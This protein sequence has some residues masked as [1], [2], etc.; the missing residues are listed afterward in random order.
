ML[1]KIIYICCVCCGRVGH[2]ILTNLINIFILFLVVF[3]VEVVPFRMYPS[4]STVA[5]I[6]VPLPLRFFLI[7]LLFV[8]EDC[9]VAL[10][11]V[12]GRYGG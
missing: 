11:D 10:V 7:I 2:D 4:L 1:C 6:S 12:V 3:V 9:I 8:I 5:C